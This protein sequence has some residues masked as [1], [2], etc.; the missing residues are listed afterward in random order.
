MP[1]D[2]FA[3]P[4]SIT[5]DV[6]E[7]IRPPRRI[8]VSDCAREAVRIE[9]PGGYTGPWDPELT[10]YMVEPMNLLKS[11][12]YEAVVF[13][14][15]AR[16]GKTQALLDGWLTHAVCADPGDMGLYFGTQTLA[17]DYRKR[18]I[19]RL[20]RNSDQMRA[21][22]SPRA[23]D[24]T[25][26][27]VTYRHGMILNLGWPSSSQLAQRDLRYVA[28]SDYDSF[29]DDIGGEGSAFDLAKKR[30]Q[31]AMS[32]GMALV[33]SS[34][35]RTITTAQWTPDGPHMAPPVDGGILPLYN[36]GDR[37]RWYWG[38]LDG[39]GEPFEAP[40]I[41]LFDNLADVIASAE[42]A[43]VACPHCGH[44]YRP[45][46]KPRL[47]AAGRWYREGERGGQPRRSTIASFWL[48]GCAA[49]MQ[50]WSSIVNNYM[51][52]FRQVEAGGDESALKATVNTDQGVPYLPK[53][54]EGT[55]GVE[56]LD[57]RMEA[58]ERYFVP[59]GVRVLLATVDV[60]SNRFEVAVWGKG[61]GGETWLIDRYRL[62]KLPDGTALQPAVYLEHWA[63]LVERVV[64]G[65]YKLADGREMRVYR[66]AVDSGGYHQRKAKADSTRIAYDWWRS[67]RTA[68]LGHRVRLIKG[69]SSRTAAAVKESFPDSRERA[70][71]KAGSRGDVP[72][73]MLN[74]DKLKNASA[75]NLA[76]ET[77]GPGYIHLP[78]WL[79]ANYLAELTAEQRS[80]KGGWEQIGNRR[81]ETWDLLQYA[82]ALWIWI[83]GDKIQWDRPPPWADG[84]DKNSEVISAEQRRALKAAPAKRRRAI[85]SRYL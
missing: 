1:L 57:A 40:A 26:E 27:M 74:T 25:I 4:R 43:H 9:T 44:V 56:S 24:T 22:L 11:R 58:S 75:N 7:L 55:R 72:V 2:G 69:G 21:K 85:P 51:V 70:N 23:H 34:P 32:A 12:E 5:A 35:K 54:L 15:P 62:A 50:S 18:R 73:L 46:D 14:S 83:G 78:D 33:E 30:V 61:L 52:A 59:D 8:S 66:T 29:P 31:V 37:R 71:R 36:R 80:E 77:P 20:H 81:N 68:G 13:V 10:P 45:A 41:P 47:N 49:A 3:D 79:P 16:T 76:R 64:H 67:L 28:L 53:R 63:I 42:T 19:E 65:T 84:L 38:C 17:Y 6:A 82:A 39:C 48:L 60:Q